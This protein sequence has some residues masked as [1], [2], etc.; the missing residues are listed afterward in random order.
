[1]LSYYTVWRSPWQYESAFSLHIS[2][3][4][5]IA[6]V[7]QVAITE[8]VEAAQSSTWRREY[9]RSVLHSN[10]LSL[11]ALASLNVPETELFWGDTPSSDRTAEAGLTR[12]D[13]L[14][15]ID[16]AI[17][18][19][20]ITVHCRTSDPNLS[21]KLAQAYL[22]GTLRRIDREVRTE[23]RF[24]TESLEKGRAALRT[25]SNR[26]EDFQVAADIPYNL[27]F[28]ARLDL[29]ELQTL[30]S[31]LTHL[32]VDMAALKAR[33]EAPGDVT[34]GLAIRSKREGADAK[35]KTLEG[36][37]DDQR[38]ELALAPRQAREYRELLADFEERGR[39]VETLAAAHAVAQMQESR[40]VEPYRILRRP[41][42]AEEPI[43]KPVVAATLGG[44]YVG[45]ILALGWSLV[46]EAYRTGGALNRVPRSFVVFHAIPTTL[47]IAAAGGFFLRY[48]VAVEPT[49]LLPSL[50]C[51]ATATLF[52]T[53]AL[54]GGRDYDIV[55]PINLLVPGCLIGCTLK[56]Y[57]I[58][59][60]PDERTRNFLLI[61]LPLDVLYVP[62]VVICFGLACL[63]VGYNSPLPAFSL[64]RIN[65]LLAPRAWSPTVLRLGLLASL[66]LS[67]SCMAMFI[68]ALGP[69]AFTQLSAKRNLESE[70]AGLLLQGAQ[71]LGYAFYF[72]L[73]AVLTERRSTWLEKL[74][75]PISGLML[76][77]FYT[78]I[79]TRTLLLLVMINSAVLYHY[80]R[81]PIRVG[82]ALRLVAAAVCIV[83]A[84]GGLR[85]SKDNRTP[86][87]VEGITNGF[88]KVKDLAVNNRNYLGSSEI[89][90]VMNGVPRKL[91]YQYGKTLITFLY[92][93]IPRIV[94]ED[95]PKRIRVGFL[96]SPLFKRK[97][98]RSGA[99]PTLIGELYLNFSLLGVF[100]GMFLYGLFLRLLYRSFRPYLSSNKNM[101]L[102]YIGMLIPMTHSCLDGDLAGGVLLSAQGLFFMSCGLL[103]LTAANLFPFLQ[104]REETT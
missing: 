13:D 84:I 102:L 62:L 73:V 20:P 27:D 90:V 46:A 99:T 51:C 86:T 28:T 9:V 76:L 41:R 36:L 74:F 29:V 56:T 19:E 68:K 22:E 14:V 16:D 101:A 3:S 23:T 37:R 11:E 1:L 82:Q 33:S 21:W 39:L 17:E 70:N 40:S 25:A 43:T 64:A 88:A 7:L 89:A 85:P 59:M 55:E 53:I 92:S 6:D 18:D 44:F 4:G 61:G 24:L 75:L 63:A 32:Q 26:L 98:L 100:P 8:G 93:P 45:V 31:L 15:R 57:F 67:A 78:F 35:L 80:L 12:M 50:A 77:S 60:A 48:L 47:V 96:V 94:W 81:Q 104:S 103:V 49:Y 2:T 5:D 91:D 52:L 71:Q 58:V 38:T 97:T 54:R 69:L 66:L 34:M 42:L 72:A 10:T 30:R 79:S 87:L 83:L 65:A 95:K